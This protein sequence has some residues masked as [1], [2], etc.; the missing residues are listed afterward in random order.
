[1]NAMGA[2]SLLLVLSRLGAGGDDNAKGSLNLSDWPAYHRAL[3]RAIKGPV[4]PVSFRALWDHPE[5]YRG[6]PVKV[7]GAVEREFRQEPI[8]DFPAL[9]ETWIFDRSGNPICIVR[10]APKR[11]FFREPG[12]RVEFEGVFLK[13]LEYRTS[14]GVRLAPLIVGPGEPREIDPVGFGLPAINERMLAFA[15]AGV[16]TLSVAAVLLRQYLN[17]P[18]GP[19]RS[20]IEEHPGFTNET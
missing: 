20:P 3:S 16:L 13:L 8:G 10:P 18:A 11:V 12:T 6:E 1:M 9:V 15:F 17:R 2:L 19:R 14:Q 5:R 7:E 4:R